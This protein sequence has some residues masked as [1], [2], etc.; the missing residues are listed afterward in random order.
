M[1]VK[2]A[3]GLR[4]IRST[5]AILVAMLAA[6]R[7]ANNMCIADHMG[8]ATLAIDIGFERNFAMCAGDVEHVARQRDA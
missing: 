8:A 7:I 5:A 4:D 3:S 2:A 1:N 6:L